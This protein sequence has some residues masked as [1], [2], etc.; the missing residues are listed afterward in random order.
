MPTWQNKCL[1]LSE[2]KVKDKPHPYKKPSGEGYV[3]MVITPI[4]TGSML[5][6][7]D[8]LMHQGEDIFVLDRGLYPKMNE[9]AS[10]LENLT[11]AS[12]FAAKQYESEAG[13]AADQTEAIPY[14]LGVVVSVEKG[15]GY[16]LIP[17]A[18][19]K[20]ATRLLYSMLE[21]RIQRGSLPNLDYG[22]LS[23]PL[24]AVAISKLTESKDMI[25]VPRLQGLAQFYQQMDRMAIDQYIALGKNLKLGAEG[26]RKSFSVASL[27]GEYTI[28]RQYFQKSPDQDLANIS[29]AN[30]VRPGLMSDH[31]IRRDILKMKN[32][33]REEDM[34]RAEQA[35]KLN[36]VITLRRQVHALID[37]EEFLEAELTLQAAE[38]LLRQRA[39]GSA[40]A[41]QPAP[42]T[43]GDQTVKS[44][45]PLLEGGGPTR[46]KTE[47]E[48]M[49]GAMN[50]DE[51]ERTGRLAETARAGRPLE[52]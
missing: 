35:E 37:R 15:G 11:M 4:P 27:K 9:M 40:L 8:Q 32:P 48:K 46:G 2:E 42:K 41:Q 49:A 34:I 44:Q 10:I 5:Q 38:D 29:T 50:E 33:D 31:T 23:F 7:G 25:F 28:K 36:P 30:Q 24:S 51:E 6:D 3:P 17:V 21:N 12:F 20:N 39:M 26:H 52:E 1:L 16:R 45:I 22:N 47:E 43:E 13:E 19:I 18:D 14:G